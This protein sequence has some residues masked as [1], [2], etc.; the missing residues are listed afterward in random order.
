[1]SPVRLARSCTLRSWLS[2]WSYADANGH[3]AKTGPGIT[4]PTLG[5]EPSL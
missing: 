4:A 2:R 3:A 1:M 5:T